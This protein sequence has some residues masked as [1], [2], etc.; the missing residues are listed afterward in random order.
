MQLE[1]RARAAARGHAPWAQT[2]DDIEDDAIAIEED[3]VD[4]KA[5]EEHVN[6]AARLDQDPVSGRQFTPPQQAAEA[7]P[8]RIGDQATL[9]YGHA[10][11]VH[12][13]RV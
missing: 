10:G 1:H 13:A 4:G 3:R 9:T 6:R 8:W 2:G 11:L 12:D 5:H 7:R